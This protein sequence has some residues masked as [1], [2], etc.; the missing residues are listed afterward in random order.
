MDDDAVIG[1]FGEEDAA[2]LTGLSVGQLR[3]WDRSG[4][5]RPSYGAD[6]RRLPFSRVYSFRNIV[7]LRVL[8]DLRNKHKVSMQHLRKVSQKLAEFGD[9][10]WTSATL[11]VL[12]RRVVFTDPR[13][14]ERK[15]IVTGQRVLDIP[16]RVA[17][18]DTRSAIRSLNER[19]DDEKGKIVRARFVLQNEPVFAGTRIPVAAVNRYL[20][21]G[22]T[23]SDVVREFPDLT[24]E[25]VDA[26]RDC[27]GSSFAA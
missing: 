19:G 5:L 2:R 14:S 4:F 3:R 20:A 1:A 9:A 15:E 12:G 13:T 17:I 21:S 7:S 10:R 25:D 24:L 16:L 8:S 18:S 22:Y 27:V 11:Y 26:A 23:P 6:N